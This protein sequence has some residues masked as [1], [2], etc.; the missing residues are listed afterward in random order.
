MKKIFY[1]V[2]I[3]LFAIILKCGEKTPQPP[4]PSKTPKPVVKKQQQTQ[5]ENKTTSKSRATTLKSR[6]W[7]FDGDNEQEINLAHNLTSKNYILVF[8][9]SGSMCETGC[10][11]GRK[12][13]DVAIEAVM[14]WSKTVPQ[15]ANLGLIA[16]HNNKWIILPLTA[17]HTDKF[18]S[19][20]KDII[21][22][23]STPLTNAFGKAYKA[24]TN[25]GKKQLGYGEYTI[26]VVT[27][28]IANDADKLSRYVNYILN[29]TP[30]NIYSIG[31][32]IGKNHTLNQPGKTIY[33][34]ADNPAQL[35][36]GLK[37]VLA[38]AKAFDEAEFNE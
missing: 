16:F 11:A 9:G 2:P 21:A 34:A 12:K 4:A 31:F 15:D 13:I 30:I 7:P 5:V 3:L 29:K 26:V 24:F 27:D 22:G 32:C 23:G 14:E 25:Q 18:N 28:G 36:Q 1:L 8:D 37:Q 6:V 38:E 17:G 19:T 20:V 35:R 10:S 33:K